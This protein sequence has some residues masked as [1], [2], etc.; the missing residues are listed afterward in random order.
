[1]PF[2][3]NERRVRLYR[4]LNSLMFLYFERR[5]VAA[6]ARRARQ[7]ISEGRRNEGEHDLQSDDQADSRFDTRE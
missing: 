2:Q 5:Q 3:N 1:M 6:D 7:A 4:I